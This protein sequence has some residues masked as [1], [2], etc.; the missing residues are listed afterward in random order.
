MHAGFAGEAVAVGINI[1]KGGADPPLKPDE[2]YPAWVQNLA[3]AE[4][5]L[6]ELQRKIEATGEES[7]TLEEVPSCFNPPVSLLHTT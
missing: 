1:K 6:Y 3:T 7:L 5:S 2:E 4:Q